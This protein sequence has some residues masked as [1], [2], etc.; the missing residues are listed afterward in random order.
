MDKFTTIKAK[1]MKKVLFIVA[2]AAV[3]FGADASI[4]Y[5]TWCG[6]LVQ[7]V[8]KEFFDNPADWDS[9]CADLNTALCGSAKDPNA[10]TDTEDH[11][12]SSDEQP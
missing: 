12:T 11:D 3:A 6:E 5:K 2:F 7:T 8:S 9:Y 10:D 1:A 4:I